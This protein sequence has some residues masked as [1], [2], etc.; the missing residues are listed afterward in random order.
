MNPVALITGASSGLGSEMA[1]QLAKQGYD[2]TLFARRRTLLLELQTELEALGRKVLVIE[3]DVCDWPEMQKAAQRTE[4]ELGPIALLIANA[5]VSLDAPVRRFDPIE[6]RRVFEVN[7]IGL[8]HAVAAVLPFMLAR[9]QGHIVGIS[10][11]ASYLALPRSSVYCASKA[12]ASNYLEGLR[13][14]L[15]SQGIRVTTVCPGFVHTPMTADMKTPRPFLMQVEPAVALILRRLK[16][17]D[18]LI[19]FPWQI[20]SLVR[21]INLL[22]NSFLRWVLSRARPT[23]SS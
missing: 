1:R 2:L 3:G 19:N 11:L 6:A 23:S 12:A 8:M 14:E 13:I 7:I 18:E 5:G 4:A 15:R 10:S 22:P 17:G 16:K 21:L 20:Y 9:K